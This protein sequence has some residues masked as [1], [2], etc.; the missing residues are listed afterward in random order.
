MFHGTDIALGSNAPDIDEAE[1]VAWF[2]LSEAQELMRSGQIVDGP[3][4]T[5]IGYFL[6]M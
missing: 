1:K 6:A 2:T 3:S 5:A 4:L